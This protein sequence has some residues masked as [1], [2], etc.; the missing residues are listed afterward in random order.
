MQEIFKKYKERL[1]NLSGR[2]RSLMMKKIYKK[3]SFDLYL[4]KNFQDNIDKD[5]LRFL[6]SRNKGDPGQSGM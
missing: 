1:V 2:N 3:H 6:F 5:I 4:L